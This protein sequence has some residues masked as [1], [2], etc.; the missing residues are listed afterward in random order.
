MKRRTVSEQI[1]VEVE[2]NISLKALGESF[3]YTIHVNAVSV[4]PGMLKQLKSSSL[5]TKF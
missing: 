3:Q 4:R 1:A 2:A 5:K